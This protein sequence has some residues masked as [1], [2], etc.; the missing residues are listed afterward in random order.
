MKIRSAQ[1]EDIKLL[2]NFMLALHDEHHQHRA[3]LCKPAPEVMEEKSIEA[4][5]N[6]PECVV[7]VVEIK[8]ELAGFIT[9][10]FSEFIS[11]IHPQMLVGSVDEFYVLPCYRKQGYGKAL[12]NDLTQYFESYGVKRIL[13]EVYEFN[14]SAIHMYQAQGF[15]GYIHCMM[16][17][18]P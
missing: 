9:G 5:I 18:L 1:I 10:S 3:D 7:R 4:Y 8:G 15:E 11:P 13:V 17:S 14:Q 2:N 12:L 16:K 6:H